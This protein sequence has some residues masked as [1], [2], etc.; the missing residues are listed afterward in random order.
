MKQDHNFK[1]LYFII[2]LALV[3]PKYRLIWDSVGAPGNTHESTL[4]QSTILWEKITAGSILPQSVLEIEAQ[5][6]PP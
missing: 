2:L 6:I 3:D 1:N 4:F 5:A